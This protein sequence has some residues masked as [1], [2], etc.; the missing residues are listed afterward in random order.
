VRSRGRGGDGDG[1][2]VG[3]WM[4]KVVEYGDEGRGRIG[5]VLI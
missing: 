4:V 5:I 1:M 3:I 2:V